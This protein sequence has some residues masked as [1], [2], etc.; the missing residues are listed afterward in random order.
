MT[1]AAAPEK[2]HLFKSLEEHWDQAHGF[3]N[4]YVEQRIISHILHENVVDVDFRPLDLD[5]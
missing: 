1:T 3:G 4:L 2:E 5:C